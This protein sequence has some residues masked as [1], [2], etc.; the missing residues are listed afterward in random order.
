MS[1]APGRIE[2]IANFFHDQAIVDLQRRQH[3]LRGN[4]SRL[5]NKRADTQRQHHA[6]ANRFDPFHEGTVGLGLG[7]SRLSRRRLRSGG[8]RFTGH[9]QTI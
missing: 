6:Q 1:P 5:C 7:S 9:L 3:R 2:V 8:I 4:V